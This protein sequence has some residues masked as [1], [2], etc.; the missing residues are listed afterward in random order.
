MFSLLL[1]S[2]YGVL[3]LVYLIG[4][5]FHVHK[6]RKKKFVSRNDVPKKLKLNYDILDG[7]FLAG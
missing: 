5:D 2:I 3:L 6:R 1:A 7:R 4:L